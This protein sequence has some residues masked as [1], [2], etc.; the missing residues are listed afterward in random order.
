MT[1]SNTING[2]ESTPASPEALP[3]NKSIYRVVALDLD[4]T[5]LNDQHQLSARTIQ[6]LRD[7]HNNDNSDLQIVL[8]TGRAISTVYEHVV[9]LGL[10]NNSALPVVC[11]NG[12]AGML[13]RIVDSD[14]AKT[15]T[16]TSQTTQHNDNDKGAV[17]VHVNSK[18]VHSQPLFLTTVP[19]AVVRT[20]LQVAAQHQHVVQYYV[21]DKIY[22]NPSTAVHYQLTEEYIRLTGSQ[23]IYVPPDEF[24]AQ[25][26]QLGEPTKLLVLFPPP[27][28]DVVLQS[29]EQAMSLLSQGNNGS[30]DNVDNEDPSTVTPK[31]ATLVRGHLGW[32]CE[33]LHPQ[34]HKGAG[35]KRL[36]AQHLNVPLLQVVAFG[37][38][39]NDVEFLQM[40]GLGVAMQNAR[41]VVK[42]VADEVIDYTNDEDGVIRTLWDMEKQGLL[43][44]SGTTHNHPMLQS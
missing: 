34:V 17:T 40:A 22:A 27:Q 14:A 26:E 12:A 35:L 21:Q 2:E 28:Q 42:D 7:L 37:D 33:V 15:T 31:A 36:C 23:T 44:S 16:T 24:E 1:A 32:F 9:A 29:L 20:A 25:M 13:C 39:D 6:G 30:K 38:G 43:A 41:P 19:R 18:T 3:K 4:G 11:S 5:L 8:A 10:P